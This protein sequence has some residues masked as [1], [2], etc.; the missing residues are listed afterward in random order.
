M[1]YSQAQIDKIGNLMVY[2]TDRLGAT[3]KTKLL[4]LV[5]IIEEEYIK[6]A[7]VPLT[8]LSF[9]HLP[10]GPVS[11]FINN[12]INKNREPLNRYVRI[13]KVN[14][15]CWIRPIVDF[16]DDEFSEFDLQVINEVLERFG[17]YNADALIDYTHRE[18]SIW[19]QMQDE[20]G[21][22][23]PAKQN[24]LNLFRLLDSEDVDPDLRESANEYKAFVNYLSAQE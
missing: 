5:Y 6:Q 13:D 24:T 17:R 14:D 11:T 23:P 7:G 8:P 9:T 2:I 3:S 16:S 12:Q 15:Q 19:K 18:G 20:F 4:K 10:K 21:G 22:P 1:A